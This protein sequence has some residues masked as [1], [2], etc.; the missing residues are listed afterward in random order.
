MTPT[1]QHAA[2]LGAAVVLARRAE[3]TA[4]AVAA[5]ARAVD[6]QTDWQSEAAGAYRASASAWVEDWHRMQGVLAVAIEDVSAAHTAAL[7]ASMRGGAMGAA[8]GGW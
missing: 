2:D 4:T 1:A 7:A 5:A 3:R 8:G 6:T